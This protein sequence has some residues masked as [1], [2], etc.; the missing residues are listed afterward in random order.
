MKTTFVLYCM[1]L[2]IAA[3]LFATPAKAQVNVND[4]LALIDLYNSTNGPGWSNKINWLTTA[5]VSTWT[6]VSIV[7]N[8]VTVLN[9]YSSNLYGT[10]P[11]SIGNLV[12]LKTLTLTDNQLNGAIP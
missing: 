6:G 11:A 8:R 5:P 7:D 10:I 1:L 4:S 9:L 3:S 12:K 2:L